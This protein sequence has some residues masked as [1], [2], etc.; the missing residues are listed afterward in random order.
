MPV[1]EE[2][3]RAALAEAAQADAL[4]KAGQWV[5]AAPD[6]PDVGFG[7]IVPDDDL[8][9]L[10]TTGYVSP[11][12]GGDKR[13]AVSGKIALRAQREDQANKGLKLVHYDP[14]TGEA[15]YAPDAGYQAA[16]AKRAEY[17]AYSHA[18]N[19][20]ANRR[21]ISGRKMPAVIWEKFYDAGRVPGPSPK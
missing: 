19:D 7:P 5:P 16:A 1:T 3:K 11:T 8:V 10:S 6:A 21:E 20:K 18:W 2:Q 13:F 4:E 9:T 17:M 12:T 14:A 15:T